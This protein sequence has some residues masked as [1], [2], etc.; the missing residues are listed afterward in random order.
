M[1]HA[2]HTKSRAPF[3]KFI[4][5]QKEREDDIGN[6]AKVAVTDAKF[7]R[8]GDY[9]KVSAY[10]NSVGAPGDLHDALADLELDWLAQ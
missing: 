7:P 8:D 9:K 10:L 2:A 5:A 4:L 3:G 6:L 1:Q